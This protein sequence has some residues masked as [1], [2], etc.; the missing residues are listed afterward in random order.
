M[1][2]ALIVGINNYPT[3]PLKGCINDAIEIATV[4]ER[5]AD[6]APNFSVR[7]LTD[8]SDTITRGMLRQQIEELFAGPSDIALFYFSGHGMVNSSGG[9]IVTPDHSP[10]DEGISMDQILNWANK[11]RAREKVVILDCCHSGQFASPALEGGEVAKLGEGLTV[12]TASRGTEYAFERNGSGVFTSLIIDALQGGAADL[13][14]YVTPGGIYS[15]VD[16]ALGAWEQRPV[17]KTNVSRFTHLRRVI[18]PI[19]VEVVRKITDYFPVPEHEFQLDPTFED[20]E[21]DHDP[22]NVAVFKHLQKMFSVGLVRPV[23]EEFMY[24]AAINSKS[25]RLTALGYQYWRM[26]DEKKL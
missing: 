15:Y 13:R 6:G 10:G 19:A 14:G 17:F 26:V 18:P 21:A 22:V 4:L 9:L 23:G 2:R 1:R 16:S 3:A 20:T 24:F 5:D 7:V 25:C 11:S 8:A 12:L